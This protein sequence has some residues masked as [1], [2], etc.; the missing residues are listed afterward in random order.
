[1]SF[2]NAYEA[3]TEENDARW[4]FGTGFADPL[5]GMDTSVPSG[6]DAGELARSCLWLGDDALIMSHRLQEWCAAA[7]E[8]EDEVA[9]A[10]IGLDL[11]GQARLLLA[12]AA[13]ADPG[14]VPVVDQS[15]ED[16]LAF[17]RDAE[18]FHNVRLV[19]LGGG[20]FAFLMARL[21]VFATWRLA[22]LQRLANAPDPVLA[23]IAV[24]GVKELT[25]H[26]DYAARW[27]VRLG[28][29]TA[30]SHD[31][32]QDGLAD[33]W[34]YVDELFDDDAELRAEFDAVIAQVCAAG[35]LQIPVVSRIPEQAG[36][37]EHLEPL[38]AEM[39]SV[40]RAHPDAT[41]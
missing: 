12:R 37:T 5:A 13:K 6:V 17:F 29:G 3:L 25:Y 16:A 33:V 8:L 35:T 9:L 36:H 21:L 20:D 31:R 1:M 28:D 32:M 11:L 30:L 15:D 34:P 41:W 7:P 26:R 14:M 22:L 18:D 23:A 10:N 38:L 4:A 39:Q 40:A 19:E 2:D 24:K 27:V